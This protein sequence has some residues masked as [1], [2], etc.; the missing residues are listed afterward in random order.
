MTAEIP[1]ITSRS[2]LERLRT[3]GIEPGDSEELRLS[4][5]LLMLATGLVCVAMMVWMA[6][7]LL[8]GLNFSTDI[9]M[10]FL[11]LLSGNMFLFVW[12]HRYDFFRVTQ[13][14]LLLFLPYAAQW[15]TGN[16]IVSSGIVRGVCWHRSARFCA[17]ALGNRWAGSSHGWFLLRYLGG[18]HWNASPGR[19][20]DA[21][22]VS[23]WMRSPGDA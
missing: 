8:F 14:G 23:R 6:L 9:P 16:L 11:L 20:T 19:F 10:I 2:F 4:K 18:W 21:P 17:S 7:Y 3:A 1:T 5:S 22:A 13:L 12:T 15:A